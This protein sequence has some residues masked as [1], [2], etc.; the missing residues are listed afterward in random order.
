[1]QAMNAND[2]S[3]DVDSS[4]SEAYVV[5]DRRKIA[6]IQS[7]LSMIQFTFDLYRQFGITPFIRG[8][9]ISALQSSLEKGLYFLS[10]TSLKKMHRV[11]SNATTPSTNSYV[12]LLYGYL[13]GW[14]P[15][16]FTMPLDAW[17]AQ[18]QSSRLI[19]GESNITMLVQLMRDPSFQ[20]YKG[21]SSYYVLCMTPAIQYWIYERL[22]M[23]LLRKKQNRQSTIGNGMHSEQ[24]TLVESFLLGIVSRTIST[25]LVYPYIRR[26]VLLQTK[27]HAPNE[28]LSSYKGHEW[29]IDQSCKTDIDDARSAPLPS[30]LSSTAWWRFV[31]NIKHLYYGIGPEL[32]RGI[33]SASIM[34]MIKEHISSLVLV[35]RKFK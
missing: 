2:D 11:L 25:L 14:V 17:K 12:Y 27:Q 7:Q 28:S 29:P 8:I 9:E 18:L 31:Q 20:F 13:S 3:N 5:S 21:L 6:P 34:L 33:L 1:M 10:Y 4:S 30:V 16:P 22:K 35:R 23:L 32:T 19:N 24:L 26:K 15:L